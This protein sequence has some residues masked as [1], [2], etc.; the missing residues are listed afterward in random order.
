MSRIPVRTPSRKEGTGIGIRNG[1]AQQS[2][3]CSEDGLHK[4][5]VAYVS[6]PSRNGPDGF[7]T[8]AKIRASQN[9]YRGDQSRTRIQQKASD[10]KPLNTSLRIPNSRGT[11]TSSPESKQITV[12]NSKTPEPLREKNSVS[13][14]EHI[15]RARAELQK[16]ARMARQVETVEVPVGSGGIQPDDPYSAIKDPFNQE[17]LKPRINPG[18]QRAIEVARTDGRLNIS[19]LHLATIPPEV[20][21]MYRPDP[22]H[23]IDFSSDT[24]SSW[25]DYADL[26]HLNGADNEI[27]ELTADFAP[28]FEGVHTIDLHNNRLSYLP[29]SLLQLESLT[30]I[31]LAGNALDYNA[32]KVLCQ[33]ETITELNLSRNKL[34]GPLPSELSKLRNLSKLDLSANQVTAIGSSLRECTSLQF[35][36]LG[37][38]KIEELKLSQLQSH[39]NLTELDVKRNAISSSIFDTVVPFVKLESVDLSHNLI[40]EPCCMSGSPNLPRLQTLHLVQNRIVTV[41]SILNGTPNL[42]QLMLEGNRIHTLP[43]ALFNLN[44]LRH[45]DLSNNALDDIPPE[46]GFLPEITQ[47]SWQGNPARMRG[48]FNMSTVEVLAYL[49]G[50]CTTD[51]LEG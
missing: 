16:S 41:G 17:Q 26:T 39:T 40:K 31:N 14:R 35:L 4:R 20:Y 44:H 18:V 48:C 32:L 9:V 24:T 11:R 5:N 2:S 42:I 12:R 25:Y 8:P 6:D 7:K 21:N 15:A 46:L 1:A 38:N 29:E 45:L 33:L 34:T 43:A 10:G 23:V 30:T 49:R 50:R 51:T 28:H 22:S 19:N 27:R 13:I 36:K 47:F 3:Y 37:E